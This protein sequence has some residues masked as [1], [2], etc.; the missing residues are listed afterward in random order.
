[1]PYIIL[2][3]YE[4]FSRILHDFSLSVLLF[5][6]RILMLI[7]RIRG[8]YI[9]RAKPMHRAQLRRSGFNSQVVPIT[10]SVWMPYIKNCIATDVPVN[11][12]IGE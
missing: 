4:K 11:L 7:L 5:P 2:G 6:P 1:M 12:N 3:V 10:V 9:L 8:T